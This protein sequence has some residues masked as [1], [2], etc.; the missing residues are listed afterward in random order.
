M[1]TSQE[2]SRSKHKIDSLT[3]D[4]LSEESGYAAF[5]RQVCM[6]A[7]HCTKEAN[8]QQLGGILDETGELESCIC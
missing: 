6:E 8:D 4:F 3:S 1:T 2:V 5:Q 7:A